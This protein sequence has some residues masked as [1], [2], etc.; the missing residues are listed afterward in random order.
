MIYLQGYRR[1]AII[2]NKI[3]KHRQSLAMTNIAIRK[4]QN[5]I[6]NSSKGK[7]K[8]T[9][10]NNILEEMFK[11]KKSLNEI[12][13][14]KLK[15]YR[16]PMTI[17][18]TE[19]ILEIIELAAESSNDYG[20]A[21]RL[22][23]VNKQWR[24]IVLNLSPLW[25]R[26][27]VTF[28]GSGKAFLKLLT[29]SKRSNYKPIQWLRIYHKCLEEYDQ[30]YNNPPPLTE[31]ITMKS[32][33]QINYPFDLGFSYRTFDGEHLMDSQLIISVDRFK[34]NSMAS[35]HESNIATVAMTKAI[36]LSM[37]RDKVKIEADITGVTVW[38]DNAENLSSTP[39]MKKLKIS[40]SILLAP[41]HSISRD[42]PN[43]THLELNKCV[44]NNDFFGGFPIT[45]ENLKNLIISEPISHLNNFNINFECFAPNITHC[46][47]KAT[48]LFMLKFILNSPKIEY[49]SLQQSTDIDEIRLA[50]PTQHSSYVQSFL[51]ALSSY[52]QLKY[53][54]I[55]A[56]GLSSKVLSELIKKN[57]CPLL[58]SINISNSSGTLGR[59]L[60]DLVKQRNGHDNKLSINEIVC[61][62]CPELEIEAVGWLKKYVGSVQC[63]WESKLESKQNPRQRYRYERL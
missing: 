33:E 44:I 59:P 54:D 27:S 37:L 13:E 28:D 58:T 40:K 12:E 5:A 31:G 22:S 60:I 62:R 61:D 26:C 20:I 45:L 2:F 46:I 10:L 7:S 25:R 29:Y 50:N 35:A 8:D 57:A 3:G 39:S 51:E 52:D 16:D 38:N 6:N 47:L 23:H 53:L 24:N 32:F 21:V 49:L 43:L 30:F 17:L 14:Q 56:T 48:K 36:Q 1:S 15:S 9:G 41:L 55:S 4:C 18:P 63:V 11:L 19:I 42:L 34:F